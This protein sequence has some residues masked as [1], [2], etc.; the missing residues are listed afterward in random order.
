MVQTRLLILHRFLTISILMKTF[1]KLFLSTAVVSALLG[2]CKGK[3]GEPGPSL[4]GNIVG[5]VN[6]YDEVGN[7]ISK[8]G[9]AVSL[10][11]TTPLATATTDAN[12]RYEF[13]GIRNGTYN[14]TFSRTDISTFRRISLGHIGGDQPTYLGTSSLTQPASTRASNLTVT[15]YPSSGYVSLQCTLAN[16]VMP[17]G[18]L[19]RYAVY[20]GTTTPVTPANGVLYTISSTSFSTATA[21]LSKSSLNS[22][23]FASNTAVYT[24][25]YGIA[26]N[27]SSYADPAT[28]RFQ[29][30]GLSTAPSNTAA[31]IVP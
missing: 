7:P 19:N 4:T 16:T 6:P 21:S 26:Y 12:G 2:G 9:V 17:S 22:L 30:S 11:G 5:F 3:D 31:F 8:A 14:A 13:Q 15:S 29:Y 20:V 1:T 18:S 24:A 25:V 28:G 10:D 23:G 27:Y